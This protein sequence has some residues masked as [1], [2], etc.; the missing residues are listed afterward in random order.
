[1]GAGGRGRGD[2]SPSVARRVE[3]A[4]AN[5]EF[6]RVGDGREDRVGIHAIGGPGA[7]QGRLSPDP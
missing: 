3:S 1:M 6:G 5:R 4:R 2:S 7:Q